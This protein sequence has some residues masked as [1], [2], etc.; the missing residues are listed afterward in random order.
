MEKEI[1]PTKLQL[2]EDFCSLL[3]YN[4]SGKGAQCMETQG[5]TENSAKSA[6]LAK[7]SSRRRTLIFV[8]A[9]IVNVGLLVALAFALLTP[10]TKQPDSHTNALLAPGDVN[11]SLIGKAAP[12]FALASL[13]GGP[14]TGTTIV[15]LA[16]FKGKVV[17][18]NFWQSSCDP[19]AA[20]APFMQ[21][22][23]TQLQSQGIVF[24]GVDMLDTA[25]GAHAFLH[26][27]G[28]TYPI[29]ADTANGTTGSDYG[30]NG[31]PETYFI[32]Q[33]GTVIAK[34]ISPLSAQG[35]QSE[36]AK[37]HLKVTFK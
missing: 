6:G 23:W 24:I 29:V 32:D 26:T 8:V 22:A 7:R 5:A 30:I 35:L 37:L 28:I 18:L 36:L 20:E 33:N 14:T 1:H 10:A 16:D 15:H 21:R 31:F 9:T 19:C 13:N 4:Y 2:D 27:Y 11:S 12:A 3:Y 25:N 34:W 17:V